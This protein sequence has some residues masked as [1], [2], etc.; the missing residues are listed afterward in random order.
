M[1]Q[2]L[3]LRAAA[4][5]ASHPQPMSQQ[6]KPC[7]REAP[8]LQLEGSPHS[9]QLDKAHIQQWRHSTGKRN[10]HK[11]KHTKTVWNSPEKIKSKTTLC[12]TNSTSRTISKRW[13]SHCKRYLHSHIHFSLVHKSQDMETALVSNSEWMDFKKYILYT[14]TKTKEYC[15]VTHKKI[16]PCHLW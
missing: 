2:L 1:P 12:S 15:S 3:R 13:W 14:Y 4:T 9:L 11:N 10:K 7:N 16:K 8:A 6:E 5:E